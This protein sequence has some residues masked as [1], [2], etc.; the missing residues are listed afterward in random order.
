MVLPQTVPQGEKHPGPIPTL[1]RSRSLLGL[2]PQGNDPEDKEKHLSKDVPTAR[3][4]TAK[5]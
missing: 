5:N 3:F 4:I 2:H 1:G